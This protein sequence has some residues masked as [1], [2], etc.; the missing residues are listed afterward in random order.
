MSSVVRDFLTTEKQQKEAPA[1]LYLPPKHRPGSPPRCDNRALH[2]RHTLQ[3]A[4]M[5]QVL[6]I[7]KLL[8]I[9]SLTIF[10]ATSLVAQRADNVGFTFDGCRNQGDITLPIAGFFVCPDKS[11]SNPNQNAYTGG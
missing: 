11:P 5:R 2:S 10:A 7:A 9:L 1:P 8:V 3:G 6:F 4:Q